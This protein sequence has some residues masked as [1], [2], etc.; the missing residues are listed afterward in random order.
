[1]TTVDDFSDGMAVLI[2]AI[3]VKHQLCSA[4]KKLSFGRSIENNGFLSVWAAK[5]KQKVRIEMDGK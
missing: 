2:L 5:G 4:C 1:M 3:K